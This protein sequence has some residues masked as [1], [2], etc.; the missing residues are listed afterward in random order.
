MPSILQSQI[1]DIKVR[2]EI[3]GEKFQFAYGFVTNINIKKESVV[4]TLKNGLL[5]RISIIS[6]GAKSLNI[7]FDKYN[8]PRGAK[9]FLYGKNYKSIKGVFTSE[10]NKLNKKLAIEPVSGEQI[11]IEY[12]EPHNSSNL[13]NLTVSKVSHDI[14][15]IEDGD[16][17]NSGACQVDVNCNEGSSWQEEKRSIVK[18]II[19][20]TGLCSCALINNTSEDNTPYILTAAHCICEQDDAENSI[21]IFNYESPSCSGVDG[22]V[23][24]SISGADVRATS[25][26]SDFSLLELSL[27]PPSSYNVYYAGWDRENSI[28]TGGVGIHHPF[29]DVKKI[30]TYNIALS[31]SNCMNFNRNNGC[32]NFFL[33]NA[34]FWRVNWIAT[35]NGHSVTEGGSSGSPLFNNQSRIVGQLWGAGFCNNSNCTNPN[36]DTGNYGKI[37]SS[38]NGNNSTSRLKDWLDPNNINVTTLNGKEFVQ[39]SIIN[40]SSLVCNAP[41]QT[42]TITNATGS[43][44]WQIS[45]K[46]QIVSSSNTQVTV[47]ATNSS[48]SGSGF[49]KAITATATTQKDV[50]VGKPKLTSASINGIAN[51]NCN[52][53]YIY[54]YTGGILGA[55]STRWEVSLQFDDVSSVNNKTLFADP[56]NKGSGYVTFVASNACGEAIFCKPVDVDGFSC[57]ADSINFPNAYSC[58]GGGSGPFSFRVS[59]NPSNSVIS[60]ALKKADDEASK[61]I[62]DITELRLYD[63]KGN[64]LIQKKN[65]DLKS[66]NVSRMK[67]GMYYL[68]IISSDTKEIHRIV[69][70]K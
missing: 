46:L 48:V 28:T 40:G 41:N 69:V 44:T 64:I 57:G 56:T 27:M 6:E 30:S 29:G 70:D 8:L 21:Y 42:Y 50:W 68:E 66:I 18:I 33:P 35:A 23:T 36:L 47:K 15:G 26:P 54:E 60:I 55:E 13:N 9:L 58:G 38:W 39:P 65:S 25:T 10:N 34:N 3:G 4:D 17:G 12:F 7:I 2:N 11:T 62:N 19:N 37:F 16:F 14:Y 32:G 24:Q 61:Q 31:D 53:I 49:V 59:P 20:G 5:Y 67:E 22:S 43:V 52:S 51:V 63:F 45:S 1:D